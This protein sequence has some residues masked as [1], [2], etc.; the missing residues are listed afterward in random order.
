MA[1]SYLTVMSCLRLR[2]MVK[3]SVGRQGDE[4]MSGQAGLPGKIRNADKHLVEKLDSRR[5]Q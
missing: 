1:V 4:V 5:S 2:S 3:V